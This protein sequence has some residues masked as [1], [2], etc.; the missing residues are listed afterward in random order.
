H[1]GGSGDEMGEDIAFDAE[2]ALFLTGWTSSADLPV[3]AG[4]PQRAFGGGTRDAFV[5]SLDPTLGMVRA[6]T[7]LGGSE[8]DSPWRLQPLGGGHVLVVGS[9]FSGDFPVTAGAFQPAHGG[10]GDAFVARVDVTDDRTARLLW[11]VR[12]SADLRVFEP[13]ARFVGLAGE[14]SNRTGETVRLTAFDL[15]VAGSGRARRD[16]QSV[17]VHRD[18]GRDGELDPGD[19]Q[20]AGPI[21]FDHDG[22]VVRAELPAV[23]LAHGETLPIVVALTA[24]Q[25]CAPGAEFVTSSGGAASF[26]ARRGDGRRVFVDGPDT[27]GP[28][29]VCR[30]RS[31]YSGDLDGDGRVTVLDVR[32]LVTRLGEAAPA[33][34]DADGDGVV[35]V[36]DVQ[37]ALARAVGRPALLETPA[38]IGAGGALGLGGFG[39]DA[40]VTATLAGLPLPRIAGDARTV[41]FR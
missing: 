6:L 22:V 17:A 19:P 5:A 20:L 15:V 14:L 37:V 11:S 4:A 3:G 25:D 39:L 32:R 2:G 31:A 7:F 13:G 40:S 36:A 18:V 24:R 33:G 23:E 8:R 35:Q 10:G 28:L 38:V 16:L 26:V 27:P 29:H 12:P 34:H 41:V 30:E 1:F 21:P 9:T